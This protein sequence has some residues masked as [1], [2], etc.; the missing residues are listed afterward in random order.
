MVF[1]RNC[2]GHSWEGENRTGGLCALTLSGGVFRFSFGVS[3]GRP[4]AAL[5]AVVASLRKAVS[6]A[7][8]PFFELPSE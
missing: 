4:F 6:A 7:Q 5:L 1:K 8:R 3:A 2:K